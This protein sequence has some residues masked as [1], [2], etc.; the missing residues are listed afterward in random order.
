VT[1][2]HVVI[3]P[4]TLWAEVF[5]RPDGRWIPVDPVRGFVNRAGL[6]ER[7]DQAGKRKAEKLMYVVAM[8]EGVSYILVFVPRK[9]TVY[10]CDP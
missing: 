5:S 9:W 4:P 1:N 2:T 10:A 3:G 6:F 8:E 7:R